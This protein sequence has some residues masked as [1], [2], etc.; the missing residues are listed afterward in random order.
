MEKTFNIAN[1][2]IR[3]NTDFDFAITDRYS[4]FIYEGDDYDINYDFML[5]HDF[6]KLNMKPIFESVEYKIYEDNEKIYREFYNGSEVNACLIISKKDTTNYKCYVYPV[7]TKYK[8]S[9]M[10]LFD[11]M[12]LEYA[13]MR[14]DTFILH[15]SFICENNKAILF[16]ASSQTGKS[17]QASLW[18][19][20]KQSKIIN[21]DRSF[22]NK[23]NGKWVAHGSP[24]AGS[25]KIYVNESYE[26]GCIILLKQAKQ[27]KVYIQSIKEKYKF[28]LKEITINYWDIDFY[29][30]IIDLLIDLLNSVDIYT[31][32]CLPN[33]GAV[34]VLAEKLKEG[35]YEKL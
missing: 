24:Y 13:M 22:L 16:S 1:I 7:Y 25:S 20:Y 9:A 28:L 32:Q 4:G 23:I 2:K 14:K 3:V 35:D 12:A 18:N 17:T 31:L 6:I 29:N 21:G 33:E 15:S 10:H 26:L 11:L 27:N 34:D 19:K 30:K 5:I 8:L